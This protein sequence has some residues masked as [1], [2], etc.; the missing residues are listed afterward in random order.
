MPLIEYLFEANIYVLRLMI[1]DVDF[2][3]A[4]K[5]QFFHKEITLL[6]SQQKERCLE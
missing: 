3:K 6:F 2:P 4:V 1:K 5:H